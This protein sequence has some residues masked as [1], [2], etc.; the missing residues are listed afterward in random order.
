MRNIIKT[1]APTLLIILF[2]YA[3]FSKLLTF[4][5][6]RGQLHNQSFPRWMADMLLYTL[7]PAEFLAAVLLSFSR[8]QRLGLKLSAVLLTAFTGYIAL[9]MLHFWDRI[10]CSC[11]GILTHMSWGT[12]LAFNA[13]FLFLALS[14]LWL[15]DAPAERTSS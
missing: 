13:C 8:S 14:S 4:S 3:G 12:H 5:Q 9:V 10:P 1:I 6:F 11:G 7:I 15:P 2:V